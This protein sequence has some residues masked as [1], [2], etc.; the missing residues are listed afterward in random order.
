MEN[1]KGYLVLEVGWEYN[2]E[3]YHTGN[4][5]TTY[6]APNKVYLDWD[7]A[8]KEYKKKNFEMLITERLSKY[9]SGGWEELCEKGMADQFRTLLLTE[10]EIDVED[11]Y[12]FRIPKTATEEQLTKILECLKVKFFEIVEIEIE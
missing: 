3:Y 12:D 2:D 1:K 9:T 4:Y 11:D 8:E 10:F 7:E 5:G 6:E